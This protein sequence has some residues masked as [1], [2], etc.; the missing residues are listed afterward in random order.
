MAKIVR[1]T[2]TNYKIITAA[3]GII[4]L[5]TTNASSDGTGTVVVLGD[6]EVK[7]A[8]ITVDSTRLEVQ[9][10]IILLSE[11]NDGILPAS[12]DRPYSSGIEID[13]GS[14][15][16]VRWVYDDSLTW[17]FNG[18]TG[19]GAW[20]GEQGNIGAASILPIYT[21]KMLSGGNDLVFA[22]GGS[23]L[24]VVDTSAYEENVWRYENGLITP[25][26]VTNS[27]FLEDNIIPNAKAVRDFVDFRSTTIEIAALGTDDTRIVASDKNNIILNIIAVGSST[28]LGFS[29]NHG[30][31]V[32][33]SI[34]I[35]GVTSSPVDALIDGLNGT[36][37]VTDVPNSTSLQI[38][39]NT[40]G[41]NDASYI[42]LSGRT[43]D[44]EPV[45]TVD[46]SNTRAMSIFDNRV[47]L[48]GLQ[49]VDNEIINL[50]SDSDIKLNA[51]GSGSVV[52]KDILEIT[53]TP[54]DDDVTVDPIGPLAPVDG[55]K[56]Y[57]K[58]QGPGGT[59]VYFVNEDSTNGELI[60]KNRALLYGMLF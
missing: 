50:V 5:D 39:A 56:I 44:A 7:G 43:I 11:G 6:L 35:T 24:K 53:K 15:G 52:I 14:I 26:P 3:N 29:R 1:T 47:E 40:T 57:S 48:A 21:D 51:A 12:L 41:A 36:Y 2:D 20:L 31:E 60:S 46:V 42:S 54:G 34:T 17:D 27:V 59:G 49:I 9:D 22:L 58:Q 37:Q 18:V 33:D 25:D 19:N 55:V 13:R 10:N 28:T 4:T 45:I 23:S 30:F 38:N 8:T 16:N 32:G